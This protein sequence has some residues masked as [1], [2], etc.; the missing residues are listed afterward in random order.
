MGTISLTFKHVNQT[1]IY[2]SVIQQ[3]KE[4]TEHG[5]LMFTKILIEDSLE[6]R[7]GKTPKHFCPLQAH[8]EWKALILPFSCFQ[9]DIKKKNH[10]LN[11]RCGIHHFFLVQ[12]LCL[13]P[14]WEA[15]HPPFFLLLWLFTSETSCA[16]D[17]FMPIQTLPGQYTAHR[18]L[19][20]TTVVR[21]Q[22]LD[23]GWTTHCNIQTASQVSLERL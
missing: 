2:N 9:A 5:S 4:S 11:S 10:T 8:I 23:Q 6:S 7:M 12:F 14:E 16:L 19:D 20:C 13:G 3:E 17:S 21:G 22:K 18:A 15:L 1:P